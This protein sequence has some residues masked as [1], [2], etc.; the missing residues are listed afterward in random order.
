MSVPT[1]PVIYEWGYLLCDSTQN[2]YPMN[3]P[4]SKMNFNWK[5]YWKVLFLCFTHDFVS[6][7]SDRIIKWA[8]EFWP[9]ATKWCSSA[10]GVSWL[11]NLSFTALL[12]QMWLYGPSICSEGIQD[13]GDD[14][15]EQKLSFESVGL[16]VYTLTN[17]HGWGLRS[18]LDHNISSVRRRIQL[19]LVPTSSQVLIKV[20]S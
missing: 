8:T 10:W 6:T 18:K 19:I 4:L 20:Q 9:H 17:L 13:T 3:L 7:F 15:D 14:D 5:S 2:D 16:S 11:V 1:F 12:V